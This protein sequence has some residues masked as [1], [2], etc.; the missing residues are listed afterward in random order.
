MATTE[1]SIWSFEQ[2]FEGGEE[3]SRVNIQRKS[4]AGSINS[5]AE[6]LK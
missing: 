3:E 1:V 2:R 4:V 6:T 5:S